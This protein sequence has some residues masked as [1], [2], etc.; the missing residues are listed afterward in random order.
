MIERPG[1]T[2][3]EIGP[4]LFARYAFPPNEL[5][6]CGPE[7]AAGKLLFASGSATPEEIRPLA[8]QFSAAWP[9]LE[10][11]AE[12]NELADP[13]DQRVVSAYWVGNELLASVAVEA[14]ANSTIVRF[15]QR[16]GR[17]VEDLTYPLLHGA[18]LHHNF[19][20]FA[21]YPWLG[22]LRNK[23]TEGPL[24]ILEQCRIRWGRVMSISSDA[25]MVASQFLAFDGWRLSLGEERIEKVHIPPGS[26]EGLLGASDR[27][28]VGDWVTSHWGWLCERVEVYSLLQL[29]STTASIISAVNS[30][31]QRAKKLT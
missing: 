15:E 16:F 31:P 23:H 1:L 19:H 2:G 22:V 18:T 26:A 11:I 29:R 20:V 24:Q 13:L 10:L 14:F 9:Y 3:S 17:S 8:R 30:L 4:L 12:A 21:I 7:D 25:I 28:Q 27:L 5:G 6:Y